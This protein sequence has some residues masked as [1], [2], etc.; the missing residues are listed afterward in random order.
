MYLQSTG[1]QIKNSFKRKESSNELFNNTNASQPFARKFFE[2]SLQSVFCVPSFPT[3]PNII[4]Q[5][6]SRGFIIHKEMFWKC[7]RG[8]QNSSSVIRQKDESRNVWKQRV[9]KH[10]EQVWKCLQLLQN[11]LAISFQQ[12]QGSSELWCHRNRLTL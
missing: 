9:W 1:R 5:H 8:L 10:R 7:L 4:L 12:I 6:C 2:V 11:W 3:L